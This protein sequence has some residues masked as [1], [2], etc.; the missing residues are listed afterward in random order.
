MAS[1]NYIHDLPQ[2]DTAFI[3][4]GWWV[5]EEIMKARAQNVDWK[6]RYSELKYPN[7]LYTLAT[8][9]ETYDHVEVQESLNGHVWDKEQIETGYI[10][11]HFN[12]GDSPSPEPEPDS[13]LIINPLTI[14]VM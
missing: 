14:V 5:I 1:L 4:V 2:R 7:D 9:F 11:Y 6:T 10:Y 8:M 3:R 13:S 12:W